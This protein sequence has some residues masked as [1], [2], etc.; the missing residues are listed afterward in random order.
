[1]SAQK[2]IYL[3]ADEEIT[4]VVEKL[5]NSKTSFITIII[6]K[7]AVLLQSIVNLKLLAK[8]SKKLE[9]NVAVVTADKGAVNIIRRAGLPMKKRIGDPFPASPE[10]A[11]EEAEIDDTVSMKETEKVPDA[12]EVGAGMA[13]TA[14]EATKAKDVQ[15]AD[16][17]EV[18]EN[19][20]EDEKPEEESEKTEPREEKSKAAEDEEK[21]EKLRALQSR[22]QAKKKSRM[23]RKYVKYLSL[24]AGVIVIIGGV[25]LYFILPKATVVLYPKSEPASDDINI[26]VVDGGGAQEELMQIP[27]EYIEVEVSEKK[28]FPATGEKE[29]GEKAQGTVTISNSYSSDPQ[30]LVSGTRLVT[31][32][33]EIYRIDTAVDVPGATIEDGDLVPGSVSV[34]ATADDIGDGYNGGAVNM[35]IP[36]LSPEKQ[37][38]IV[39]SS[40]GFTGGTSEMRS[41][42]SE[43]NISGATSEL[44]DVVREKVKTDLRL[45][46]RAGQTLSD[47]AIQI[48]ITDSSSSVAAGEETSDFDM[49]VKA[50][51]VGLTFDEGELESTAV[52]ELESR[53]EGKKTFLDD[54]NESVSYEIT[55]FNSESKELIVKTHVEKTVIPIIETDQ[56]RLEVKGLS[57]DGVKE[58]FT[59]VEEIEDVKVLFWPFWVDSV[60]QDIEK[61][62]I[63]LDTQ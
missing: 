62:T 22:G 3:E 29:F 10:D 46:S 48:E 58:K 14:I 11:Q 49:E 15:A 12:K 17:E 52:Q 2:N 24:I 7:N 5:R 27:G 63:E 37:E 26:A 28:N 16:D 19:S 41:V 20:E 8:M 31:G 61:I 60:P 39:A 33:G 4:A 1:M 30:P 44:E 56:Y 40:D 43:E 47:A 25:A 45:Q 57:E 6:P 42:V 36:G 23:P 53:L 13:V 59:D 21:Q 34:S 9:K 51:A 50:K 54:G 38:K 35:T 55:E 32:S 18:G